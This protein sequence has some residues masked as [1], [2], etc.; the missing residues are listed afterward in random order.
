MV[1][2]LSFGDINLKIPAGSTLAIVAP[3]GSGQDYLA[4]LV[5]RLWEAPEGEVL[6]DG[7]PIREWPLD[8]LRRSIGSFRKT[9]ICSAKRLAAI[10]PSAC[11]TTI[12]QVRQ[13]AEIASLDSDVEGFTNKYEP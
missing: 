9:L 11:P 10:S 7:R 12:S 4:A 2:I 3:T 5:A 8:S 13:A 6:I 1:L